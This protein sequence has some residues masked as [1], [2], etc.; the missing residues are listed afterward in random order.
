MLPPE[1]VG[2]VYVTVAVVEPVVVAV[3]IVG[4]PGKSKYPKISQPALAAE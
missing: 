2:A 4:A 3:P 1:L